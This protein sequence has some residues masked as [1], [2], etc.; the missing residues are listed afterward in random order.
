MVRTVWNALAANTGVQNDLIV[1]FSIYSGTPSDDTWVYDLPWWVVINPELGHYYQ[2]PLAMDVSLGGGTYTLRVRAWK[3]RSGG[4]EDF[5]DVVDGKTIIFY[6]GGS[7][8]DTTPGDGIALDQ[9]DKS[10]SQTL[11]TADIYDTVF[12]FG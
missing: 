7:L 1:G 5:R 11:T 9:H 12:S 4:T 10:A 6:R 3:N 2:Y 8:Y